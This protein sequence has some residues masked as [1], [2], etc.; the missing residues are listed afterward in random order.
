[1]IKA[2]FLIFEPVGTW[3]S[4]A[5]ARRSIS[6]IIALYLVP[7][8]LIVALVEG[9][10][11]VHWGRT[12]PPLGEIR[13]YSVQEAFAFE[14][15]QMILMV[16]VIVLSA[17]FIKSFGETFHA[18]NNY[19]QTFTVVVYGLGPIF[20]LRLLDAVPALNLWITWAVGAVLMMKILYLGVPRIME[21]DPPHA[22]G[23]YVM[24]ALL[25]TMTTAAER[26]ISIGYLAGRYKPLYE[27]MTEVLKK[28]H[29]SH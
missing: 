6:S 27:V 26:F 19:T 3:E 21:P 29:L 12:R 25:L 7:M 24:S 4:V 13:L 2:L 8:M 18:R 11:L 14:I 20:L 15:S 1:M 5:S 22:F 28:I 9:Y 10:G 23:L 16:G 17:Y